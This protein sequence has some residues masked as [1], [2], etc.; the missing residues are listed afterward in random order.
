MSAGVRNIVIL[1]IILLLLL[2]GLPDLLGAIV[3]VYAATLGSPWLLRWLCVLAVAGHL[4]PAG[5][6]SCLDSFLVC[7]I[8]GV[9]SAPLL[10]LWAAGR[11][12]GGKRQVGGD[13][14]LAGLAVAITVAITITIT[15]ALTVTVTITITITVTALAI[16]SRFLWRSRNRNSGSV[17]VTITIAVASTRSFLFLCTGTSAPSVVRVGFSGFFLLLLLLLF[18]V[19]GARWRLYR[20]RRGVHQFG[21]GPSFGLRR[22]VL[23]RRV[24]QVPQVVGSRRNKVDWVAAS[25]ADPF[26]EGGVEIRTTLFTKVL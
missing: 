12:G 17:A 8:S 16:A 9:H 2:G 21:V 25:A 5:L 14:A 6:K 24:V 10:G 7:R 15:V 1:T 19:M 26:A 22:W 18:L 11:R 4:S 13:T 23:V 20:R 3:V